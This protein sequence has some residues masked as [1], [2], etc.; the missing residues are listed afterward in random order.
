SDTSPPT[1][2]SN[3]AA[4]AAS[5]SLINLAWTASTD[6][7]AV[8]GYLVE[9]CQGAGCSNFAQV[10][11]TTTASY[12]DNGLLGATS[13]S[14]RVRANDAANN[15]SAYSNTASATTQSAPS[16]PTFVQ[17]NY[18]CPQSPQSSVGVPFNGA[19]TTGNL[20]VVV[21]GWN[22]TT[23]H[24]NT[25]TD[26]AGNAYALAVGPTAVTGA[27]SQS[28]YYA[29]NV[30]GAASNTVNVAFSGAAAFA[31]IRIVEY[32][33][34]DLASPLDVTAAGQGVNTSSTTASV[35]T[36]NTID[37]LVGANIVQTLTT[38]AGAG[39]TTRVITNP[40]G[41]IV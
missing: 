10:G 1:A 29:K 24:V 16:T 21:V 11:M 4:T 13:Y 31:D 35:T 20:N 2:P 22:D 17:A 5:G 33:G 15:L 14:Y 9:R 26:T 25:V 32:S 41:D 23:N 6:T 39:Y 3:L 40:D 18:A 37:L 34:L 36:T 12:A 19:Q 7:V 30:V 8:A 27:I 38:G 28:I